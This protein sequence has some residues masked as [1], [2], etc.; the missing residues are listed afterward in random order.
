MTSNGTAPT[1]FDVTTPSPARMYNF[2]LGGKDNFE[3]D[4]QAAKKALSV[5]PYGRQVAWSNRR[6]LLRAVKYLARQGVGQFIDLGPG[7]PTEPYVH[8]VAQAIVPDAR[9]AYI[10]YDPIVTSHNRSLLASHNGDV[11]AMHGDIRYPHH[12]M[13]DEKLRGFIDFSR[14][15]GVLFVAV[16]HFLTDEDDP[17]RA[18]SVFRDCVSAGSYVVISHIT[19]EGTKPQVIATIQDAYAGASAPA[20][21]RSCSQIEALFAGLELVKPGLVEVSDW[22]SSHR[23]SAYSP[24]L[25][26]LAGVGRKP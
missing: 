2:Y 22:R 13:L 25:Q 10:D 16:L 24:A 1:D 11:L 21:F 23:S 9:V 15:V 26:F 18:V 12:I 19:S 6:F 17:Y 20:V 7:I 14:P 5:V 8:E 4:R 3:A